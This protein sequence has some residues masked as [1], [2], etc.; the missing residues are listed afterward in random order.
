MMLTAGT[1]LGCFEVTAR[2]GAGGMGEVYRAKDTKLGREVAIKTL[3]AAL[4]EDQDRLARFEREAK[5]LAALHHAH[6]ASVFSLDEHDGTVYIAMELVAGE[7]LEEKLRRGVP[8]ADE[9][10]RLALQIALALE[11]AH[12]KGVV[13]RD[14]KPANI[15]ITADGVV[16][17]LDFGLA[18]AFSGDPTEA[19]PLH[20]PA[21]SVAMT[22]QGLVLGTAAYMSPEQASGQATDHRADIWA[23]GVVLYEMLTGVPMFSGESAPHIMAAV[24]RLEPDWS[25]LPQDLHPRVRLLLDRCLRKKVRDRYHSMADVRV[26]IEDVLADPD[27]VSPGDTVQTHPG[28]RALLVPLAVA[29]SLLLAAVATTV[30]FRL[31]SAPA[32]TQA[33]MTRSLIATRPF[34]FRSPPPAGESRELVRP[35]RTNVALSSD[36]RTVVFGAVTDSGTRLFRRTLDR[37][38][39]LPIEGTDG[40]TAPF[41]SP[42]DAWI[43]FWVGGELRRVPV[44]G[45]LASTIHR[46]D[47]RGAGNF[48]ADWSEDGHIVFATAG[49]LW[50]V[51]ADGGE[52]EPLPESEDDAYGY[53]HPRPLPGGDAVLLTRVDSPFRWDK[54]RIVVRSLLDGTQHDVIEDGADARY[55]PTGHLLF[56]RRGTLMAAPFDLERRVTAGGAVS[57]VD[58]V[59]QSANRHSINVN[60]SVQLA[61]AA[62]GTLVYATG[63]L[64]PT[65]QTR[66]VWVD[67]NGQ[68]EPLPVPLR[69]YAIPRLTRDG[70]RVL[71]TDMTTDARTPERVWMYDLARGSML[72]VTAEDEE[73]GYALE[74]PDGS[75]IVFESWTGGR[76]RLAWQALD[77]SGGPSEPLTAADGSL[78]LPTS[79]SPG[80]VVVF[81]R[82]VPGVSSELWTIDTNTGAEPRPFMQGPEQFAGADFSPDGRW[83]AYV[84]D[85][86]GRNEVYVQPYPGPGERVPVST[87]GGAAPAWRQ[88]GREIF[89]DEWRRGGG[90]E[91]NMMAVPVDTSD[92]RFSAGTPELLFSGSFFTF[93]PARYYD[94][95]PD[96]QR[97]LMNQGIEPEPEPPNEL[98]L[99]QHWGEELSRLVPTE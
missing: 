74:S 53:Y 91:V 7:T 79:W 93:S 61:V 76:F 42:D 97:F 54:A 5:L 84:S 17:V 4:A 98:V 94:V 59:M 20:S 81:N 41:F 37:L 70:R 28:R 87:N 95:T 86:S 67:R 57:L 16:K 13:H 26:D 45:G 64:E 10:L 43:A 66:L 27:G 12:E 73:S 29:A 15:M 72:P 88:D 69:R 52:A 68:V 56:I 14:L 85:V 23:F 18:K 34:D 40:A 89:Y 80:G 47:D 83:I 9:A 65:E 31:Y 46:S 3:P 49:G 36:G 24:L 21:L 8:P 71:V 2:I 6:I 62:D 51:A 19:S 11:A 32:A 99:V 39:A 30:A 1:R 90:A 58:G 96:G 38:E 44:N 35:A 92:G 22:Q 60:G 50:R 78:P 25:R 82:T 33:P 63:G 48:G 55:L 77:R 75:R